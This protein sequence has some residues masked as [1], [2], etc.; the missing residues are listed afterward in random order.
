MEKFGVTQHRHT[1]SRII[2][3][4]ATDPG[5]H[6]PLWTF[7]VCTILNDNESI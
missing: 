2:R 7:V 4:V 3:F 5:E 6:C 1:S